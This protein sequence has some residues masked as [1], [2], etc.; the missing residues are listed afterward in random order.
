[1]LPHEK[2]L[3][4]QL[5]N[6]PFALIGINSDGPAAT[7]RALLEKNAIAWRQAIDES[8]EGPWATKWNVS[9]WPTIYVLDHEGVIRHRDLRD[10]DLK[11]AVEALVAAAKTKK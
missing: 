6:E 9:G 7:V 3:V 1:M 5:K 10:D 8:T 2:L 4:E 11:R